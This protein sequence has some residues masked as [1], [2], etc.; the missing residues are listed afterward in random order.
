MKKIFFSVLSFVLLFFVS[1]CNDYLEGPVQNELQ[2]DNAESVN[3][4]GTMDGLS[5]SLENLEVNPELIV[6]KSADAKLESSEMDIQN[7]IVVLSNVD[8]SLS[9]QFE[10]GRISYIHIGKYKAIRKIESIETDA[11]SYKLTTSQAQLGDVFQNGSIDFSLELYEGKIPAKKQNIL[12]KGSYFY[13]EILN[14]D[15]EYDLNGIKY[16]PSTNVKF[17][18][19]MGMQFKKY[20][21]LPSKISTVFEIQTTMNPYFQF[22]TSINETYQN[23][24]IQY[25]PEQ[26]LDYIKSQEFE[27]QIPINSLGIDSLPAIIKIQD[28]NIPTKIEA[29]ISKES[30]LGYN[31][32]GIFKIGYTVDIKSFKAKAKAIYENNI[33]CE[34]PSS[35]DLNGELF[36]SAEVVI[37]PSISVFDNAYTMSGDITFGIKTESTGSISPLCEPVFGSKGMFTSSMNVVLDLILLKVPIEILNNE[38]ELWSVGSVTKSLTFYDLTHNVTGKYT[39]NILNATRA[40]TTDFGLNYDYSVSG[41]RLPEE[42]LISYQVYQDNG[43][44]LLS[45]VKQKAITISNLTDSYFSFQLDIP[46]KRIGGI[47][48]SNYQKKSYIKNI[49]IEDGKGFIYNGILNSSTNIVENE[50]SIT[51]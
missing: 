33:V 39:N 9:S 43:T 18:F 30:H 16:N 19:N 13:E 14:L 26:L 23:D 17:L 46:Y 35:V 12:K 15:E 48:S 20:Q 38:T 3:Q 51:R 45:T 24:L 22:S 49:T 2:A 6:I 47:L 4:S 44:T 42:I 36:T 5:Y 50:F 25:V 32:N 7:G 29:N 41:K 40:Y 21:L 34:N 11:N 37:I 1:S 8:E 10:I 27:V 31:T 28:I